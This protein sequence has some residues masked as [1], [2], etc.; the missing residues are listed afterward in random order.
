MVFQTKYTP[1]I[2]VPDQ[3]TTLE[4][5]SEP[6]PSTIPT[7]NQLKRSK[8][9]QV[10]LVNNNNEY[11]LDQHHLNQQNPSP[12]AKELWLDF[13]QKI[14]AD[15][16]RAKKYTVDRRER[17]KKLTAERDAIWEA[18]DAEM[19]AIREEHNAEM[20][21]SI[22]LFWETIRATGPSPI[23]FP[24]ASSQTMEVRP[25]FNKFTPPT[26]TTTEEVSITID[27]FH[28]TSITT[29]KTS[30]IAI[31]DSTVRIT[32]TSSES[33]V[34]ENTTT[35]HTTNNFHTPDTTNTNKFIK[36][37]IFCDTTNKTSNT[38]MI[39]S[40]DS[41]I[42]TTNTASIPKIIVNPNNTQR[43]S[44]SKLLW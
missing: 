7:K 21:A 27:K 17:D 14:A 25:D 40:S 26:T 37:P 28:S 42:Y 12:I 34:I 2:I 22:K 18:H 43:K 15:R 30:D 6:V 20:D 13:E 36:T 10:Q 33:K 31:S 19:D 24:I 32:H 11:H 44:Y 4:S 8:N 16:A 3:S 5:D 29:D 1:S 35:I 9:D 23:D 41:T 39:I 38:T